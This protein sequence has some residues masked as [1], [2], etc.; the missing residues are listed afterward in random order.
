MSATTAPPA[1][2]A[3]ASGP[4]LPPTIGSR[5]PAGPDRR[6]AVL[7][8]LF[9]F[10]AGQPMLA[11]GLGIMALV[12]VMAVFAP[13]LS[14]YNPTTINPRSLAPPSAAHRLGTDYPGRDLLSLLIYGS[15]ASLVAAVIGG[16]LAMA[17]ALLLGVLPVLASP[18]ADRAANRVSIFLLAIPGLP[19]MVLVGA[20][21]GNN[22]WVLLLVIGFGGIAYNARLLRSQALAL[23]DRGFLGAARGFG[24]GPLYVLRRHLV[25]ALGPLVV[26]GFVN[27]AAASVLIQAALAFIGLGDPNGISWGLIMNRALAQPDLY[28]SRIWLWWVLPPGLAITVTL[29]GFTLVGVALEPVFNPRWHRSS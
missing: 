28:S 20:L 10:L 1:A 9:R 21:V 8:R 7:R 12:V 24:G 22:E 26:M 27:W 15:R 23:R 4:V 3:G 16:A 2:A 5:A 29:L 11:I 6:G 18:L 25:P 14:P 13:V 17:G 19:L